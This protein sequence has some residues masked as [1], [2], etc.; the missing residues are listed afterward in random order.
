MASIDSWSAD[1]VTVVLMR[2]RSSMNAHSAVIASRTRTKRSGTKTPYTSVATHGLVLLCLAMTAL[3]MNLRAALEKQILAATVE[4][5]LCAQA[6][7]LLA[8]YVTLR[9]RTGRSESDIYRTCT[10]SESAIARR[11][12]TVRITSGSI[13][14]IVMPV[15]VVNGPTCLKMPACWKRNRL[16]PYGEQ[17]LLAAGWTASQQFG[18]APRRPWPWFAARD[19]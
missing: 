10:N 17:W 2:L 11:S 6:A 3:S 9:T 19:N 13:S 15:L 16:N 1:N 7:V 4:R 14:S 12:S 18:K 8:T 5:S